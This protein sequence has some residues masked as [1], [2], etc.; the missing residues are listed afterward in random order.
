MS[1]PSQQTK[2]AASSNQYV[3]KQY[4]SVKYA[5]RPAKKVYK[6]RYAAR[7]MVRAQNLKRQYIKIED[8][9]SQYLMS[10][11]DPTSPLSMGACIPSGFPMPSQ[12]CRAFIRATFNAGTTGHGFAVLQPVLVNDQVAL[13]MTGSA[14]VGGAGTT[15][16]TFTNVIGESFTKLPYT[17]AQLVTNGTVAGRVVSACLRV[18]YAGSESARSGLLT[19]SEHPDHSNLSAFSSNEIN[20]FENS[21]RERPNGDGDWTTVCW[22]GPANPNEV[23]YVNLV[24][25]CG[26]GTAP[27]AIVVDGVPAGTSFEV[28]A[29]INIEY[30]GKDSVGK[31]PVHIDEQGYGNVLQVTKAAS[32][33][34]SLTQAD[35]PSVF[36]SFGNAV[37]DSIPALAGAVGQGLQ[38][39]DPMT[40]AGRIAASY[41]KGAYMPARARQQMR[42]E[43]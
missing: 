23:E 14:S 27:L 22:S 20:A 18:R 35:A 31:T 8:C 7:S 34:K 1:G 33:N 38:A 36:A 13:S 24:N 40:L 17:T 42:L 9:T 32:G 4:K 12:K 37:L 39:F 6:K 10:L 2:S 19:S 43:L 11:L 26:G 25:P 16:S 30:I 29:W 5:R 3:R 28:E 41:I 21:Y 15:L